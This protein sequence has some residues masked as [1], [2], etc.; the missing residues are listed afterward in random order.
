[1][2]RVE[3]EWVTVEDIPRIL[4]YM[5]EVTG[6]SQQK[7]SDGSGVGQT[8]VSDYEKGKTIP[9]LISFCKLMKFYG[10]R[11]I[12]EDAQKEECE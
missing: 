4:K 7:V 8:L 6:L 5:R 3:T 12:I 1:M 2:K 11:V 9:S 10:Y